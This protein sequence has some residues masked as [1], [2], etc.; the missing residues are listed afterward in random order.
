MGSD[1]PPGSSAVATMK[2]P[3][4]RFTGAELVTPLLVALV[5]LIS[6]A[7]APS[8]NARE[9][10]PSVLLVTLDTTIPE[11]L[12]C[13]GAPEGTTPHLDALAAEGR[14][15]ENARTVAPMTLPAHASMMTGL[16][17]VRHSVRV[18]G[19]M[20][21]P[22]EASTVAE[23]AREGRCRTAAFLGSDVL[24]ATFGLAQGFEVYDDPP[25][26]PATNIQQV[27][28]RTAEVVADRT[29]AWLEG[30]E[31]EEQFLAWAH[32]FD[33]HD[34]Y[35][36]PAE[37]LERCG[38][39]YRG[40]VAYVDRQVGRIVETLKQIDRW[41][42]TVVVVVGDHGEGLGRH[43]E[44]HHAAF[45]FDTTLRVPLIVRSPGDHR[46]GERPLD[47]VSVADIH[48]TLLHLLGLTSVGDVDG[49]DLLAAKL[50]PDRGVYFES[51]FGFASFGWSQ[52]SGWAD[53]RGK[54]IHSSLPEFF[55]PAADPAE[56]RNLIHERWAEVERYR[57]SIQRIADR[58]R[59]DARG[60]H[61]R[62]DAALAARIE[63]L[64]YAGA[65]AP[66]VEFPEPLAH[67]TWCSP[68]SRIDSYRDML[69][70]I[71]QSEGGKSR[72]AISTLQRIQRENPRNHI[73][74]FRLGTLLLRVGRAADAIDPLKTA[75]D[76]RSDD[77]LVGHAN[78]GVAFEGAGQI[79]NAIR[80][81]EHA[82]RTTTGGP[83]GCLARLIV[84]LRKTGQWERAR[85]HEGRS[86]S[87]R[88]GAPGS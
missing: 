80:A 85:R 16:Y 17:P 4:V 37:Y 19:S 63:K 6:P 39:A 52:I 45:A 36:P 1:L 5:F 84:L 2:T 55:D 70:A 64:G 22:E 46:A 35:E 32:F 8:G 9:D 48:P 3:P 15:F 83:P 53:A 7:C 49:R 18:N 20:V 82:T 24:D 34:P 13:Y 62:E 47:I 11:A 86:K 27:D 56:E 30:L 50:D 38:S 88:Q 76:A 59:L 72:K 71:H 41:E 66:T 61:A 25:A 65:G 28:T 77:W 43:G 79:E 75:I 26:P 51:Y 67:L 57:R 29:I 40:E 58:D 23:R 44:N 54:Y 74:G 68:H 69:R 73:A 42:D 87:K 60:L 81:Y 10:P 21:L 14:L 12:S 78:L 33:A 31:P